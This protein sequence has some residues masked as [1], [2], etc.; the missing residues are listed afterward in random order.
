MT[1]LTDEAALRYRLQDLGLFPHVTV[2]ENVAAPQG[3][4]VNAPTRRKR[5][6]NMLRDRALEGLS[7]TVRQLSAAERRVAL[8]VPLV[9]KLGP[10]ARSSLYGLINGCAN[11][12]ATESVVCIADWRDL[13]AH[14]ARPSDTSLSDWRRY[15]REAGLSRSARR[16]S[17]SSGRRP[18]PS[19]LDS[20]LR[21]SCSSRRACSTSAT[22]WR[23]LVS[24]KRHRL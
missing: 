21:C 22:S 3:T 4:R 9:W 5:T 12:L 11:E 15:S 6:W 20:W 14:D 19:S 24:R 8:A 17:S 16:A 7:S 2:A 1:T 23:A 13:S 18:M 10:L